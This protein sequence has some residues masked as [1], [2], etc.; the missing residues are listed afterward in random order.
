MSLSPRCSPQADDIFGPAID[1]ACRYGFDFTL[2]FEQAIL[3]LAPAVTFLLVCPLR[4][5]VLVKRDVRTQ[6]HIMRSA[7]LITALAFAVIQLSLLITWAK[8]AQLATKFSVASSAVNLAVAVQIVILSWVEDE[9]SVRPSSLLAIYLLFTLLFDILQTRTLWFSHG[10]SLIPSLF[11]VSV[12]VKTAMVL[13]ESLGKQK[14]LIGSY[15][16]LPPEST[17]GI[18]NASF[19]WWLNRLFFTG[20]RSLLTTGDLDHLDKPLESA[21]TARKASTAW[22]SRQCP[23]RRFEFPWQMGRAFKGPIAV[24]VLPRLFLIGFTFSQPFLI[25]SVLNWLDNPHSASNEGY[26]VV[27]VC[28][29]VSGAA[30]SM[31]YDHALH[32][33]D[34]TLS[35]R[36]ATIT[37]MTTDIDRIIACLLELNEFWS[38]TIEVGI[39]IALLALRLGWVCL[40]PLAIVLVSSGGTVYI[41][42]HIGG[43]QKIWVVAVQERIAIT[44]SMLEG[45]LTVKG[46]G[47]GQTFIRL[48]QRKRVQETRQMAKYRW[49][50]VWKNMVQNLPWALA[51]ALTFVIYAAQGNEINA[52]NAFSS[53]SIITLLTNPASKLL[54]AI[55]SITA[56]SGSFDRLQSFL[57]LETGPQHPVD[58][59][60]RTRGTEIESSS[61]IVEAQSISFKG[62]QDTGSLETP[63]ISMQGLSIRPSASS[64]VVLRDVSL[65]VPRGAL[66]IIQG[67]VGSGKSTLLRAILGQ[68]VCESGSRTVTNRQPAFCA[69]TPWVPSGTIRDAICGTF[70][71]GQV[72]DGAFDE[73]WYTAVLHACDL[74][75]DLDLLPEGDAMQIGHRSGHVL[76]GGQMHRVA[77][78]RAVYARRKL[79]LL[80]DIFSALDSKTKTTIITRLLGV[81]GLLRKTNSTIVL[82]THEVEHL[83]CADQI[84]VLSHGCL[85]QQEPSKGN[86]YQEIGSDVVEAQGSNG[87]PE[88]EIEHKAA[89]LSDANE[90]DDLRRATGDSAVYR[91]YLR[92]VGWTNA[93]IFV[94]FVIM[95]VFSST[96]SHIWLQQWADRGGAQKRLYVTVYFLLAICNTIGNGGYVWA[97]LILISPSTARRLHYVILKTVLMATPQFLAT[98]DIGSIL[99]RFSQDMTLIETDL[100][101]GILVTVSNLF[102]SIADAALIAT[103]SKYMAISVPFLIIS[104]CLLQHFYLKTSRQVRL[105]DLE[106]KSPLYSH[107]LDTVEGLA[108]IQAFGWEADFRTAN[109]ILLDA[110]Q[111]T[112][113]MLHCT[114]RWLTLVL[115]LVVAAEAVIVVTLAV[116]LRHTTSVGLLGVSLNSVLAFNG[117]LSSLISGWTQLEISLGSILRVKHFELTAPC[118]DSTEQETIPVDW[119]GHGAIAISGM[120]AHYNTETTTLNNVS[121]K[122][123]PGQRIGICGRTG[124][125]KSSLLSTLLG[126]LTMTSGSIVIDDIDIAN[127]P[128]D[129]VRERLVTISQTPLI[130]VGC[131]IRFNLDPTESLPDTVIITALDRVGIWGGVLLERGGLD[132]KINDTLSLSRGEQQLLQLTRAMLKI[133]A[134]NARI[135]LIDEGTSSVDMETDSRVQDLLQQDPFRTCTVLTVAHRVHT[136]L[137]YDLVVVLDRG[138]VLEMD[139]PLILS[140]RKD[141]MFSSLLNGAGH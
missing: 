118:E 42:K 133:Q 7:K 135:L 60:F 94:F 115:D 66:V 37:L 64:K 47:L 102:S 76:S 110:T 112:Y 59:V 44:R 101:I 55:P 98:V 63:V 83:P 84:Y 127:I 18:F 31:V 82:V 38:R 140:N 96:Y 106:S 114:Q 99:N 28:D 26:D 75:S 68:A 78:A 107:L 87:T 6:S 40:M 29:N 111:R 10:N 103:G 56:A 109:S 70:S 121:L 58:G 43:H 113:Y 50:I 8:S 5:K 116:S 80:D 45:I 79:L 129:I 123:S 53:L 21:R 33:P 72:K 57:L 134:T 88:L 89:M 25:S 105:L 15:Q 67:Q 104:V 131:T 137:N 39:G 41:S 126:M 132:A 71:A 23:A 65:Q 11:T 24:T 20:F 12:A 4:L 9:R 81:E 97:I 54:S 62:P 92:Y 138:E 139:T 19:M 117:S 30:S 85:H 119:P 124:S 86:V 74:N 95:N 122:C 34:G 32:I 130:M 36:S 2:L 61:H 1:H 22:A 90:I 77:L 93:V 69:Q 49:S 120:S 48:V 13:F 141:S 108:T 136:F 17:S 46:T 128:P 14:H 73:R 27:P 51:P 100:P 52:T 16:H 91:Y 35:D 125:G 3:G